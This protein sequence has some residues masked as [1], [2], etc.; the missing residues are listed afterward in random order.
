MRF[1]YQD[2]L[3]PFKFND[4]VEELSYELGGIVRWKPRHFPE[5]YDIVQAASDYTAI[6]RQD[7]KYALFR[8]IGDVFAEELFFE[9]SETSG[10][11]IDFLQMD[12]PLHLG[13]YDYEF[14][15]S[16]KNVTVKSGKNPYADFRRVALIDAPYNE[17]VVCTAKVAGKIEVKEPGRISV[18]RPVT[19]DRPLS[20][21]ILTTHDTFSREITNPHVFQHVRKFLEYE[22]NV[23][24]VSSA[25][26]KYI[27]QLVDELSEFYKKIGEQ[28]SLNQLDTTTKDENISLGEIS[29]WTDDSDATYKM[30]LEKLIEFKDVYKDH[31]KST[32]N[33]IHRSDD[34]HRYEIIL[35]RLHER[36]YDGSLTDTYFTSHLRYIGNMMRKKGFSPKDIRESLEVLLDFP[37]TETDPIKVVYSDIFPANFPHMYLQSAAQFFVWFFNKKDGSDTEYFREGVE[38]FYKTRVRVEDR[39]AREDMWIR[40]RR[41]SGSF[42]A[43]KRR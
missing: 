22:G 27:R 3:R 5:R 37:S 34:K 20:H 23:V 10:V 42:E 1:Q 33:A 6:H 16:G 11:G 2:F 28:T 24:I 7:P 17:A 12:A 14:G 29:Q 40:F 9:A 41:L 32:S 15:L 36:L 39:K 38:E 30:L 13:S 18:L 31:A 25:N 4:R 19:R 35:D 8:I 21:I 26:T 43:G